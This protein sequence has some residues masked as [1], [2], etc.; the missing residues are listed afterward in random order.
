MISQTHY[1]IIAM[2]STTKSAVRRP[3]HHSNSRG[4]AFSNPW[5]DEKESSFANWTLPQFLSQGWAKFPLEWAKAHDAHTHKPVEVID[6]DFKNKKFSE[7][8][9]KVQA[10]WLGH[11]VSSHDDISIVE[12]LGSTHIH[13]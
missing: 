2:S 13:I 9:E 8:S 4:T 1:I 12:G 5:P 6:P 3:P 10:T 7:N 11:A